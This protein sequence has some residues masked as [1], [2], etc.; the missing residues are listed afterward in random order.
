MT[1]F[2]SSAFLAC[3]PLALVTLADGADEEAGVAP[4]A[5]A[6]AEAAEPLLAVDRDDD[7]LEGT[8]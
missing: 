4:A 2:F 6:A 3:C 5:A 8:A 7:G 1:A